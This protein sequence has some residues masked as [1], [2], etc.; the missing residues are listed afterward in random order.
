M[1]DPTYGGIDVSAAAAPGAKYASKTGRALWPATYVSYY[2]ALR[3]A[4]WMHNGQPDLPPAVT[5]LL[6]SVTEDGVYDLVL[7]HDQI[8]RKPGATWALP[9]ENEMCKAAFYVPST[10]SYSDLGS[11][12][13]PWS[14]LNLGG[15]AYEWTETIHA[16]GMRR[17]RGFNGSRA[18][19]G[20]NTA[21]TVTTS[22]GMRLVRMI[23]T[24]GDGLSDRDE[25][26]LYGTS[27]TDGD[28]D[29]DGTDDG[30]EVRYGSD[31]LVPSFVPGPPEIVQQPA[32]QVVGQGGDGLE[33][34]GHGAMVAEGATRS[35]GPRSDPAGRP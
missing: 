31:P 7:P 23:D 35:G 5:G 1:S 18:I 19:A 33:A 32:S 15:G 14:L 26:V 24:D 13:S 12:L 27:V 2:N 6:A 20:W 4:N 30:T 22:Y 11:A 10:R 28:T 9:T 8:L 3:F 25:T 29:H 16:S 21:T 17:L 34:E